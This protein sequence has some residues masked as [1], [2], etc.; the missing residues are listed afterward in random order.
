MD[1]KAR[2]KPMTEIL[3]RFPEDKFEI[4][5]FGDAVILDT[6]IE[7]WPIVECLIAFQSGK[8][9]TEKVLQYVN[10]RKPFLI[11]DLS[12]DHAILK[13][14]RNVYRLLQETGIDVP[15]H[16]ILN[17]DDPDVQNIVEEFD[18]YIVVNGE[19]IN[20][21]FV[22][23]PVDA[24]DH[25][26]FIYYPMSAGGGSKRL[27]RKIDDRSSAF[28][29]DVNEVRREGSFIYEEFIVTQGTDV[30]V[31]TVGPTYAHAEARKSP[32]V[33][34]KVNRDSAGR[35]VRYP[36]ILSLAEKEISRK[37]TLA[38]KQF[39]CGFD[40]LRVQGRSY[41]CDV[42][43]WSF[44]KN[45]RKYYDDASAVL[46]DY[47]LTTLRRSSSFKDLASLPSPRD[48]SPVVLLEG[49]STK[50]VESRPRS[51][52][53]DTSVS[54]GRI[55]STEIDAENRE[56]LRS[57]IAIIRHGDRTPKQ[58]MKVKIS[59]PLF[60]NY[61]HEYA[62]SSKKELKVKSKSAL[63]KFLETTKS[64]IQVI[65]ERRKQGIEMSEDQQHLYRKLKQV[66]DVFEYSPISGINRKLQMKPQK[67]ESDAD[68]SKA[69]EVLLI[70]KWGGDLTPLGRDQAEQLGTEF[71]QTMYPG[72]DGGGVLRLHATY[73]H[74]L[75]IKASDEGRVMK[76]AAS[77][78]KGLLELE[79]Q[80]TPILV[81]LVR[82][83][84][85]S[86][87]ILD[88]GGNAEIKNETDKC[89]AQLDLLQN[90]SETSGDL[91][92][93]ILQQISPATHSS[94]RE[95]LKR[96]GN[97]RMALKRMHSL[98]ESICS[99]L[100][101]YSVQE[102]DSTPT[103][104][105]NTPVTGLS[106]DSLS[107]LE[108]KTEVL[109]VFSLY[110]SETLDMMLERWAKLN[111]DFYISKE[112]KYDLTK[113]PDVYDMIRY[114]ILHNSHLPVD[115]MI[116]L[117]ELSMALADCVVPQEYGIH[118]ADKRV[119]GS[120]LCGALLQKIKYDLMVAQSNFDDMHYQLDHSHAEDLA[121]NSPSRAVR[122]R[123]YF[124]S[125]SH[126]H[127]L[128]NV[129]RFPEEG[130]MCAFTPD[131]L[132]A[133]EQAPELGYLTGVVFRMFESINDPGKFRVEIMFSPGSSSNVSVD[134]TCALQPYVMINKSIASEDI[135]DCLDNA[136]KAGLNDD[137]LS[138]YER[139]VQA[140]NLTILEGQPSSSNCRQSLSVEKKKPS[141]ASDASEVI[142][143][144]LTIPMSEALPSASSSPETL[145]YRQSRQIL[146]RTKSITVV[147]SGSEA[148]DQWEYLPTKS[149]P[150]VL[151][152]SSRLSR[153]SFDS[154]HSSSPS[155]VPFS[156][157]EFGEQPR[158]STSL[159]S[160]SSHETLDQLLH[161]K[162]PDSDA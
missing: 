98:I 54:T 82:V 106:T 15:H 1:K 29:A 13:D 90:P 65:V 36:V 126:L 26:I 119:I 10:L 77:F 68:D 16:V 102:I 161:L 147:G 120:K 83:E 34:G 149:P 25:N 134:K 133:L 94:V 118:E 145:K 121:I 76:T 122:T 113:V 39:V 88:S 139:A 5:I 137:Q 70:V 14:R 130:Q 148:A 112:G 108:E 53:T 155:K 40:I 35:E 37:I 50:A 138:D 141:S 103:S 97:P 86:R 30:K 125:E 159:P 51:T 156:E 28:H 24:E 11:N 45:S 128:L 135:I 160:R 33:D 107:G 91:P 142:E 42:N 32:V 31:Y 47:M 75:K 114:D 22:E 41:V 79:G 59:E 116:E 151:K 154:E 146:V 123:L 19:Q 117:F 6:D 110:L 69:S 8:Y 124:T 17:R 60:L 21:P 85:K 89:K 61:F 64:M 96:L 27:F 67:W 3:K 131:G 136:I 105:L 48:V 46:V 2:S 132:L 84:E 101:S 81:S 158:L 109:T 20:K 71:R 72:P 162:D 52:T 12:A 55:D 62:K 43:G 127:S 58:K 100:A 74:D 56:E 93:E 38:F 99:Q 150:V 143:D 115:G 23:K 49:S 4:T 152:S 87:Q 66:R 78:T 153:R 144:C 111:K 44:V 92:E 57:V 129:L 157:Q 18:E 104:K 73:R 9:P 95:G 140:E 63:L 7:S 80:L